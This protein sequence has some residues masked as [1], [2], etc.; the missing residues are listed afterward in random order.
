MTGKIPESVLKPGLEFSQ[1]ELIIKESFDFPALYK[2]LHHFMV[3]NY[4]FD[5][6][7]G[8]YFETFYKEQHLPGGAINHDIRWRAVREPKSEFH[9]SIKFIKY[10]LKLEMKTIVMKK[11]EV[12]IDGKKVK[13][14]E[15]ELTVRAKFY[16]H[17]DWAEKDS[18]W[19]KNSILKFFNRRFWNRMNK[20]V[21]SNAKR[22]LVGASRE[23]YHL[24]QT[25]TGIEP[26]KQR[27]F[28]QPKVEEA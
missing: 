21:F 28:V 23:I 14:N 20:S 10:Y 27:G 26:E 11:T 13:M 17:L 25:Y 19:N 24:I 4:W 7:G 18:D 2:V 8:D 3:E 15:G 16:L 1:W 22:E 5:L 9:R 6:E 12:M